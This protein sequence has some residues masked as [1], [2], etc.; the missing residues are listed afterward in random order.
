MRG[1]LGT[2]AR[3][4]VRD[5]SIA[6]V[7]PPIHGI[8]IAFPGASHLE[9][10]MSGKLED[11]T[12]PRYWQSIQ[13]SVCAICLDQGPEGQCGLRDRTCAVET[14]LPT[15]V[16]HIAPVQSGRMDEYFAAVEARICA[17]CE[18]Y[19]AERAECTLRDEGECALYAYLP[20]VVDA[21]Q[22]EMKAIAASKD[23]PCR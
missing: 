12:R 18:Y 17:Q 21:L 11:G 5:P 7:S 22:E 2:G 6:G 4:A 13:R 3:T 19:R 10:T 20:L 1:R 15:L 16:E 14:H 9:V 8:A 23:V